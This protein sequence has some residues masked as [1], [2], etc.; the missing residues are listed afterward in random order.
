MNI[1]ALKK[2]IQEANP[3]I[4]ELKFGCEVE[5]PYGMD[6]A[7]NGTILAS[8]SICPKH[9]RYSSCTEECEPDDG[10]MV[11]FGEETEGYG[12]FNLLP[13]QFPQ[14]LGRPIQLQNVIFAIK[15]KQDI[16]EDKDLKIY[17]VDNLGIMLNL[18]NLKENFDNQAP[19]VFEFL[20][21]ILL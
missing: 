19:E 18:W 8:I 13:N 20:E 2:V 14:I 1:Q 5:L 4:M 9:K 10:F 21:K 15:N 6:E 7:S 17:Q 3:S 16:E 11:L 12:T